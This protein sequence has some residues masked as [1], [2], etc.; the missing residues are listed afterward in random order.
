[1]GK[2]ITIDGPTASGK[3][4]IAR[5]I[6]THGGFFYLDTGLLY[7]AMGYIASQDYSREAIDAAT[8]WTEQ[9]VAQ[10][11]ERL[12]YAYHGDRAC[13]MVDGIDVT[14]L[15]RT[16]DMDWFASHVSSVPLVRHGLRE[17]QR[18]LA[19]EHDIVIDGRDCGTVLFPHA[20]HKFFITAS[21]EV[22]VARAAADSARRARGMS[23]AAIQEAVCMRD[24]RDLIR[25]ISPLVPAADARILD[26]T[27][28]SLEAAIV[29]VL[30][31]L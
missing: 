15:L 3:G 7:R 30:S 17:L 10:Y 4:S 28:L 20:P 12:R 26:T 29:L 8:F 5:A 21:L 25:P 18:T 22:R 24:V 16:P 14:A 27:T 1:M 2:Q 9:L 6:A 31:Y 11:R 13:I 19:H 23:L